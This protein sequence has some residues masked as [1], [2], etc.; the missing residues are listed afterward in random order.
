MRLFDLPVTRN[1][2]LSANFLL[3]ECL[4]LD[5]AR[6]S[7]AHLWEPFSGLELASDFPIIPLNRV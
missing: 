7:D 2:K 3:L 1:S 6:E 4:A 5:G